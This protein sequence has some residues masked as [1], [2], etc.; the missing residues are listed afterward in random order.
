[1]SL[2][3]KSV[4]Y[5]VNNQAYIEWAKERH[6]REKDYSADSYKESVIMEVM[7]KALFEWQGHFFGRYRKKPSK[8]EM[9]EAY[10]LIQQR[11]AEIANKVF[12]M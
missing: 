10:Q 1:M 7:S 8:Q 3:D 5:A 9:E 4:A 6:L 2:I 11:R 12:G